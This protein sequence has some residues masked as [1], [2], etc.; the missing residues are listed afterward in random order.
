MDW[1]Q[2]IYWGIECD[3]FFFYFLKT[4][5]VQCN[6]SFYTF[7]FIRVALDLLYPEVIVLYDVQVVVNFSRNLRYVK[8]F[9]RKNLYWFHEIC[10]SSGGGRGREGWSSVLCN[11]WSQERTYRGGSFFSGV[12][13]RELNLSAIKGWGYLQDCNL[14]S[15]KRA[16]PPFCY[17]YDGKFK[18]SQQ[19]KLRNY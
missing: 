9:F 14:A 6:L 17:Y 1:K 4:F 15:D 18:E 7:F 8:I 12:M 11:F 19:M 2:C 10:T 5:A 13:S 16:R 3:V